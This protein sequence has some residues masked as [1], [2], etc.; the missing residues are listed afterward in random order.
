MNK[1]RFTFYAIAIC[2][3]SLAGMVISTGILLYALIGMSFPSITLN[4]YE[5]ERYQDND[6]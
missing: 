6:S 3:S 5:Y 1:N 2:F 4:S